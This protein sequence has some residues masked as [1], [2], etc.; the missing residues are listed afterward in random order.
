MTVTG[1][2]TVDAVREA[3]EPCGFPR[4]IEDRPRLEVVHASVP[5]LPLPPLCNLAAVCRFRVLIAVSFGLGMVRGPAACAA[6]P[7]S[8]ISC[9]DRG[10]SG[11]REVAGGSRGGQ[12]RPD[13]RSVGLREV[14]EEEVR[15]GM[16]GKGRYR[17]LRK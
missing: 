6:E 12:A 15:V 1:S 14:A 17:G 10:L 2:P 11:P 3:A 16:S 7:L 9:P 4:R 8:A 5:A 13:R